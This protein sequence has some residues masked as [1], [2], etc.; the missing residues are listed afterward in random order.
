LRND[1]EAVQSIAESRK[2][3][4]YQRQFIGEQKFNCLRLRRL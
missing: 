2:T 3:F 1:A 4:A